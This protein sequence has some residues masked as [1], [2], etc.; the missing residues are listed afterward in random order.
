[1]LAR[2]VEQEVSHCAV[3]RRLDLNLV[4][5]D[6][7]S[8]VVGYFLNSLNKLLSGHSNNVLVLSYWWKDFAVNFHM[9]SMA[10]RMTESMVL[11]KR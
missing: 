8:K 6:C 5:G 10:L 2:L 11:R 9:N 1:M 3:E 7:S 4:C